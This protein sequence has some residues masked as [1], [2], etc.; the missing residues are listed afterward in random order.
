LKS[1]NTIEAWLGENNVI[2][3]DIWRKKYQNGNES[4]QD[5]LDRVSANNPDVARLILDKKFLFG[6][7]ILANRGLQNNGTKITYSNCYVISPP[8][9][10]L[11][12]IFDCASKLARTFSYGG[13]VGIDLSKLAPRGSK[14]NNAAKTT[15]GS[16]SFMDLYSLITGLIAQAGRRGALMISLDCNHPDLEEF[17]NIKSDLTKV[18]KANISIRMTDE[19]LTAVKN[20]SDYNL[21]Y[22]RMETGEVIT[23]KI[24]AY[25]LFKKIAAT[26]W[27]YAEPGVIFWDKITNYNLLT[28]NPEFE[29]AGVNPCAE[30]PLPS[31]GSCLLG[32]INLAE[33]VRNKQFDFDDFNRTV[34][35]AVKALNDVLDEGL[36]LHPLEEQRQS[37]A[38]WRQIGLGIMGLADCLIRMELKYGSDESIKFCDGIGFSMIRQAMRTSAMLADE[39]GAYAKCDSSIPESDF[40]KNNASEEIRSEVTK[41]RNSQ[42]LTCAPTGSLSTMLGISGGIEPI[43]ANYYTRKT[44]SLHGKDVEYKVYT[45]IVEQYMKDNNITDDKDLPDYF[46]TS[47]QLDYKSRVDMQAIWQKHIDAS[48]SSTVNLPHSATVEDIENLYLYA[49]EQGLKG[50]TIYRAG[51]KRDG[52][53]TLN[54]DESPAEAVK[55]NKFDYIE[56]VSKDE[57]GETYGVNV[58]R[59]IACGRLYLNICRDTDGNLVEMFINTGKGGICQSNIN[60]IS[61]LVSMGLRSGVKV[62][63]I[64]D[65]LKGIV[66][67][68]CT[69]VASK[70]EELSGLSCGD[71]IARTL[72]EEYNKD[73]IIIKKSR[74]RNVTKKKPTTKAIDRES[75]KSVC[76]ECIGELKFEGGCVTCLNCGYSKCD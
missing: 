7:R 16:V 60:A 64:I 5:W 3:C 76:P 40:F 30:E 51:C 43:Y 2:G 34:D 47:Q 14:I 54:S 62:E 1:I 21:T 11:E 65:Q 19:F 59:R 23:K 55:E 37:V 33:F 22:T 38:D 52:I 61:R 42:L 24:N 27:D 41:L 20:K 17:I 44:E 15:S 58:K 18:T 68:A 63:E 6:G 13:G 53:L 39:L 75:R 29:Y 73:E 56:P 72:L 46:V 8:E 70:G 35:I 48:I 32:S 9:D 25:G 4:F 50:I 69:K 31:G 74:K 71:V 26:N 10:N 36:P 57:L 67:P 12:S 49:W 45:P 28:G 66:C